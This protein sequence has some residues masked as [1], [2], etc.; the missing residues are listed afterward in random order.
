MTRRRWGLLAALVLLLAAGLGR[1]ATDRSARATGE[2]QRGVPAARDAG[3]PVTART[4]SGP[5]AAELRAGRWSARLLRVAVLRDAPGGRAVARVGRR[6]DFGQPRVFAVAALRPGWVG[7]RAVQ[8]PI[9]K[10]G[11]LPEDAVRLRPVRMTLVAD[12]SDRELTVRVDGTVRQR[13]PLGIGRP[14]STTPV[15]R[16]GVTDRL[17]DNRR[18]SAAYGCCILALTGH[19]P[20]PPKGWTGGTRLA[21]HSTPAADSV[22]QEVSAGCLRMREVDIRRFF[23]SVPRGATL[24]V[25][26]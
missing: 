24:T 25:R 13:A 15:G 6:T 11:W 3:P 4:A 9:G 21:L 26:Q 20:N 18:L 23:T 8:R 22:G 7:V 2:A 19:Q 12:L 17:R 10:L 5:G 1:A 14:G 16:Y